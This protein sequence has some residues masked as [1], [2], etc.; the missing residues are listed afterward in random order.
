MIYMTRKS[1]NRYRY[2]KIEM[3]KT[4]FNEFVV[5]FE[6]GSISNNKPTRIINTFFSDLDDAK[7][8][9]Q[10]KL[11]EKLKKGYVRKGKI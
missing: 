10:L 4:L 3:N 9:M 6:F 2:Y 11:N 1:N 7:S 5:V 8:S